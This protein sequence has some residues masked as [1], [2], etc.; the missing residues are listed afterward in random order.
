MR[1]AII[2]A[3]LAALSCAEQLAPAGHSVVLLDKGRG[4]GGRMSTRR[5]ATPLGEVRFDHGAPFFTARDKRFRQ[6]VAAWEKQALVRPWP[7]GGLKAWVGIPGM[8]AVVKYMAAQ[9][10]VCWNTFAQGLLRE[11]GHWKIATDAGLLGPF[12]SVI[13]ATPAEQAAPLLSLN[14]LEMARAASRAASKPCWIGMFVFAAPIRTQDQFFRDRG[15]VALAL[16][17]RI[18]PQRGTAECWVVHATPAW[19]KDHVDMPSHQ[20]SAVLLEAFWQALQHPP[21]PPVEA[22]AHR[23][24]YAF[25]AENTLKSLWNPDLALGACGDWLLGPR[26][27]CAWLSGRSMARAVLSLAS[28]PV[29]SLPA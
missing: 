9:H 11:G 17:N 1:I 28:A 10:N 7:A 8:N 26:A 24:R 25:P 13:V 15:I 23:W 2:G 12:D 19:S 14:D 20:V 5:V 16:S 18:K 3:G 29:A 21:I 22:L 4:P 27:E 6:A